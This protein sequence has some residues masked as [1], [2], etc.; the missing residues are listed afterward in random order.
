VLTLQSEVACAIARE[1]QV[2]LTPQEQAFFEKARAVDP[3][4]YEAYLKGR[5]HWN[6]R[7][8]EGFERAAR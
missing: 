2:K 6:R 4:A 8:E 5:Y 3:E 7:S 1:I